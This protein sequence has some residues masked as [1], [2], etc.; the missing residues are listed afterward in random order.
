MKK[1]SNCG[2]EI[3]DEDKFCKNCGNRQLMINQKKNK[4]SNKGIIIVLAI[5][6]ILSAIII[7][8]SIFSSDFQ[9]VNEESIK[10][11]I[12]EIINGEKIE[13]ITV[14][15]D[16]EDKYDIYITYKSGTDYLLY[17]SAMDSEFYIKIII[18]SE[19]N[20]NKYINKV[21]FNCSDNNEIQYY[22]TYKEI[23]NMKESQIEDRIEIVDKEK[24]KVKTTIKQI[25]NSYIN[26]YKESCKE[27]D[28]KT[29]FRYI[30]EYKG[31][32]VKFT[33][34][35]IQVIDDGIYP[36]YRVNVTKDEYGFY[37]D[38]IYVIYTKDD[39]NSIR[40]LEDDIITLYGEV[41]GLYSYTSVLNSEITIPEI[42]A[43]Y[44]EIVE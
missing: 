17:L 30:E 24:N 14:K 19:N 10:D 4:K 40:I 5:I 34:E 29:L 22:I 21:I 35:V 13:D 18:N 12:T 43:K 1:C 39:E 37:D 15:K 27:Y 6:F 33:G 28:Y 31:K 16:T 23:Y 11:Y 7:I 42:T 32:T 41:D 25:Q 44:I 38:T 2:F 26:S 9:D 20:Y 8:S 36:K 3:K